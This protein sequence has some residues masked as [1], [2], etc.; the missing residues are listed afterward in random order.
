VND[1]KPTYGPSLALDVRRTE[2]AHHFSIFFWNAT[3]AGRPQ[4]APA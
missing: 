3:F 1:P 2:I 4:T